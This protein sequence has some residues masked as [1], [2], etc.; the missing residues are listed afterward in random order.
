MNELQFPISL[1][2][3]I[4]TL[5]SDFVAKDAEERTLAYVRQKLF[6]LKEDIGVY[7]DESRAE[8]MYSIMANKWLDF[9]AS[10]LFYNVHNL[11]IGRVARKGWKSLWQAR[12]EVYDGADN[13]DLLIQEENAW[14]KVADAL[15]GEIPILSFFTGYFFNPSYVVNR[16]DG[17][18]V[19]RLTK[20]PSFFGRKFEITKE[21]PFEEGE[22]ERILLSLMMLVLLERRRG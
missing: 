19:A 7:S 18:L 8:K 20:K 10:Y 3:K 21:A 22:E 6:K 4:S 1:Q 15:L 2:F 16:P 13:Q 14:I 5:A 17:T 11:P 12:Y 9:S